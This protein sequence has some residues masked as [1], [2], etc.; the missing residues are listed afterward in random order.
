MI[1]TE[2]P[3]SLLFPTYAIS[4]VNKNDPHPDQ[5]VAY[6]DYKNYRVKYNSSATQK[7]KLIWLFFQPFS[8]ETGVCLL[9]LCVSEDLEKMVRCSMYSFGLA[10]CHVG[11]SS[12][13][14][15]QTYTP[16]IGNTEFY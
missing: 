12:L 1:Q 14:R 15:D 11:A 7:N 16:Y 9:K 10:M 2:N 13:T 3:T 6:I 8:P 4:C 5:K